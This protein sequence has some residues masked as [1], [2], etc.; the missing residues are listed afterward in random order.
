[1]SYN[2]NQAAALRAR[3]DAALAAHRR[4]DVEGAVAAYRQVLTAAPEDPETLML[5]GTGLLQLGRAS[6]A[7]GFLESAGRK[8]RNN[9]ELLA[10]L[11]QCYAALDRHDAAEGAWRK[12]MRIEPARLQFQLGAAGAVA[13]QGRPAEAEALLRRIASRHPASA[14]VWFNLG[15]ALRDQKRPDDAIAAYEKALELDPDLD[16]ARNNLGSVLHATQRFAAAERR[17][18]ECIARAPD[19]LLAR[20]NL[21]SV[22][23]DL[24]RF[25]EAEALGRELL[26]LAPG[27]PE[28]HGLLAAAAGFQGR[29]LEA[30]EHHRAAARCAP[31]DAKV[32]MSLAGT[33]METGE[34][35]QGLRCFV[36]AL[37]T[38]TEAA[39]AQQVL[40][41]ALLAHGS[42][43]QGWKEYA[44]R[45]TAL[46]FREKYPHLALT[47]SLGHDLSGK[48]VLVLREQ[49]LGDEIFFLRY[50]PLLA[51]RGA[52]ISYRPAGKIASLVSRIECIDEVIGEDAKLPDADARIMV[53]DLPHALGELESSPL[54]SPSA[55]GGASVRDFAHR[56]SV[57]WPPAPPSL[58]FAADARRTTELEEKLAA[59]GPPPYIGITWR[60]G[61]APEEQSF[62]HWVLYKTIPMPAL[63][64]ALR[65]VRGTLVALQRNPG[66]GEID[67]LSAVAGRPVHDFTP[68]NEDLE[69]MLALLALLDD[70]V[71]VSNTNVHLRAT[72]GRPARVL[73]PVPAEWRWMQGGRHS[74][75]FPDC[76]VYRQSLQGDWGPALAALTADL[77]RNYG[78]R[79]G[80]NASR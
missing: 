37:A 55:E 59:L 32:A 80:S 60:A 27:T 12:A 1:M 2:R 28:V 25:A 47:R 72:V 79:E 4:G 22:V 29:M 66:A 23:M 71:T 69:G 43:Q 13:L 33:L 58:R 3:I 44:S 42:L 26:A 63:G 75:W 5:L 18:R 20:Y 38:S 15:N 67:A 21:A 50:A 30:R 77:T 35:A 68:L 78:L 9:A 36:K 46:R 52:R 70:Y 8:Q 65:G 7:V 64:A 17:Y 31:D 45:P 40:A 57:F 39:G 11:A 24:G 61:T 48:H 74:P 14:L 76:P 62:S 54:R 34:A 53:G 6:E 73:V 51:A 19:H 41:T 10:N 49:G 16:D 56:V